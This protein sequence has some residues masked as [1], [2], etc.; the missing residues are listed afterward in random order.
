MLFDAHFFTIDKILSVTFHLFLD[1]YNVLP[2]THGTGMCKH[3]PMAR[4]TI[5]IYEYDQR[6]EITSY[7][8]EYKTKQLK[9]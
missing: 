6:H 3:S 4:N 7:K 8:M 1:S 9:F 5:Y 2:I